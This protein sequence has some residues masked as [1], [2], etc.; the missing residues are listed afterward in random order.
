[1]KRVIL[2]IV[3]F[4]ATTSAVGQV[5]TIKND[6]PEIQYDAAVSKAQELRNNANYRLIWMKE[7]LE[8]RSKTAKLQEKMLH[9]VTQPYNW[10]TVEEKF[11]EK[12]L[13][14]ER[15]WVDDA[16]FEKINDGQ[17]KKCKGG[18]SGGSRIESGQVKNQYRFLPAID[19]EGVKADFY[20]HISIR[21]ANKASQTDFVT[22]RYVRT[23]RSWYSLDGKLLKKIEETALEGRE[24]LLR[25]TTTYEY[26][27]KDLKIKAPIK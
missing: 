6:I 15:I 22:V 19:F 17:W 11:G 7:Y 23:T 27:P 21:A 12:P 25:E 18:G 10:R 26:D 24:E 3:F 2:T 1:M 16:L 5:T 20:E 8:D 9:E 14:Q 4:I 13:R